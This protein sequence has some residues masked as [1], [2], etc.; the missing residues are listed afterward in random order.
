MYFF[1]VDR[2]LCKLYFYF[3]NIEV[4]F[5]DYKEMIFLFFGCI[6]YCYSFDCIV[7]DMDDYK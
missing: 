3:G 6:L 5:Y 2:V 4:V 7:L 1:D